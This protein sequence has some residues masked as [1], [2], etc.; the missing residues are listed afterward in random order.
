VGSQDWAQK[1]PGSVP[2]A[3]HESDG[4]TQSPLVTQGRHCELTAR[5]QVRGA[6]GGEGK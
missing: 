1:V 3:T 4:T 5:S 2:T 6:A